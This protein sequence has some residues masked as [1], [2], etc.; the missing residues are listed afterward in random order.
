MAG[1]GA[2]LA[3]WRPSM[4]KQT[5]WAAVCLVLAAVQPPAFAQQTDGELGMTGGPALLTGSVQSLSPLDYHLADRIALA[6]KLA[7]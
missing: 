1:C 7:A 5:V 4:T 3:G 2:G 6:S